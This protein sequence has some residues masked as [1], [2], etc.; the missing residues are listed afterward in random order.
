MNGAP[1]T[2]VC[3]FG[4]CG[5]SLVMQMLD[6]GGMNCVGEFP[7]Y[8]P[9]AVNLASIGTMT[10][11][12]LARHEWHAMK[13]LDPQRGRIEP[14]VPCRAIWL[15]R[16]PIQQARSAV[17][18]MREFM[19]IAVPSPRRTV[20]AFAA[21]YKADRPRALAS[22]RAAGVARVLALRFEDILATPYEAATIIANLCPESALDVAKMA[23]CV[24]S[25]RAEC[26]PDMAIE[27]SLMNE[28][29]SPRDTRPLVGPGIE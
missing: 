15:D 9:D 29:R 18:M 10:A 21:A 14:G 24:L 22:L 4:R 19:G 20:H 27:H 3:G 25:R 5:S 11:A 8:E 17:K 1:I 28:A 7:D 2:F 26:A 12:W 13:I 6:A 16:D 23:A